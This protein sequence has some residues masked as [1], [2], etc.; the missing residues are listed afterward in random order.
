MILGYPHITVAELEYGVHRS[1]HQAQNQQA[2][3]QFLVPLAILDFDYDA[4]VAYGHI[5]G[6]LEA[7]GTP[8]GS[9]DTLIAAHALSQQ[10]TLI[11]SNP[12]EFARVPGLTIE[13]WSH[14]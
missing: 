13:D 14:P 1:Q 7:L 6:Y 9:L 3:V 8:I 10:L 4:A 2:L 11:T 12:R 5:R